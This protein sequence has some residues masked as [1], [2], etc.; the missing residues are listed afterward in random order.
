MATEKRNQTSEY[1]PPPFPDNFGERLEGLKELSGLSW[2][3]F[4]R[5]LGVTQTGMRKWRRGGPPSGAYF[6]AI[7]ELAREVPGG[8]ALVMDGDD[9]TQKRT[10]MRGG[11]SMAGD[12]GDRIEDFRAPPWP[13]NFPTHLGRLEDLSGVSLEEFARAMGFS[14]ERPRE[15]RAGAIP[16][17][18][19]MWAMVQWACRVPGGLSVLL[20]GCPYSLTVRE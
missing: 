11:K 4:G 8:Y 17:F 16:D 12:E 2:A 9:E 15:W 3:E 13:E 14:E 19:E 5:R 6:W 1:R 10:N 18:D 7:I 20:T